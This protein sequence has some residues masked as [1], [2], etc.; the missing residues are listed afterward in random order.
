M[1]WKAVDLGFQSL[2]VEEEYEVKNSIRKKEFGDREERK[3]KTWYV[4]RPDLSD[5]PSIFRTPTYVTQ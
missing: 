4:P 2:F 3:D 1:K 5:V